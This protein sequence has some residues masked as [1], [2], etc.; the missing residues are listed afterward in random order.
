MRRCLMRSAAP[1]AECLRDRHRCRRALRPGQNAGARIVIDIADQDYGGRGYACADP[2]GYLWWFGSYDP[3]RTDHSD[4]DRPA[5]GDPLR[6][7][8]LGVS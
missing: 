5:G 8:W 1:D 4:R 3:W 7:R 6:H 2:E